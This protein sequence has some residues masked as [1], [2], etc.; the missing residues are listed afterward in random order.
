MNLYKFIYLVII[1][2]V[3]VSSQVN[4]EW[5]AR[6]NGSGNGNDAAFSIAVD[7]LG[8]VYAAGYTN[9][10]TDVDY[11]TI[12]YNSQGVLQWMQTYNGPGNENDQVVAIAVDLSGNI[13]VTGFSWAGGLKE[14]YATIKYNSN[15]VQQWV[16]RYDGPGSFY[17]EPISMAVDNLGNV[18]VTGFSYGSGTNN[19][20]ATIKYNTNGVIQWIQRYNGS[21]N[22]DDHAYSIALDNS[23]NVYVTGQ[24]NG[25]NSNYQTIKYNSNGAFQ[26]SQEY[27]GPRDSID[28]ATS[29]TVDNTGD[30]Y[31]TGYS[32]GINSLFDYA[33]IKYNSNGIQQWVQRYNGTG[34]SDDMANSIDTDNSN[35]IYVTGGST[36]SGNNMDMVTI[37]YNS[38]GAQQWL[39]RFNGS[40]NNYDFAVT[41]K[42][43]LFGNVYITGSSYETQYSDYTTIKYNSTGSQLWMKNYNGPGN[44]IDNANDLFIDSAANVYVTGKSVGSNSNSDFATIKYSQTIGISQVSTEIPSTFSLSQNYP[45]PFNPVTNI[46]FNIPKASIVRIS[47]YDLQGREIETLV[48]QNLNAG[49]YKVDWDA[50]KYSSGIYY[51][52]ITAGSFIETKKMVLV[53]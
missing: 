32:T 5:V 19:D 45:N 15:G 37:K 22:S 3:V 8:N 2:P 44:N 50:S 41:V 40:S 18:Y 28:I 43:D 42:L 27:N 31:V 11:L 39:Q 47:V 38:S 7:G 36:G 53:K 26:W 25:N 35:N 49:S 29:V 33:T 24:I 51:Y 52:K 12:K 13:Y 21:E 46:E 14:D 10:G 20:F 16:Q 34:N 1:F 30:I 48:Y 6:Y 17:D 9:N 23:H 4:Q